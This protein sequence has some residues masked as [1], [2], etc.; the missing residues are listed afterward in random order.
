[1]KNNNL[2]TTLMEALA[3]KDIPVPNISAFAWMSLQSIESLSEPIH[4][5]LSKDAAAINLYT[6]SSN[7]IFYIWNYWKYYQSIKGLFGVG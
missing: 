6:R 1:M 5:D 2:I 7:H 3:V 4:L